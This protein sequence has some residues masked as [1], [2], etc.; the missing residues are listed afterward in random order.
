MCMYSTSV[1]VVYVWVYM[2]M[3]VGVYVCGVWCVS[4]LH[5]HDSALHP[6]F[7]ILHGLLL[8][9]RQ[10]EARHSDGKARHRDGKG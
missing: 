7:P 3:C 4:Y 1:C 2:C 9:T 8:T 10:G 6:W 5:F